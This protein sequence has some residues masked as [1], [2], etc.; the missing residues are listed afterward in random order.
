MLVMIAAQGNAALPGRVQIGPEMGEPIIE[1]RV[2][3]HFSMELQRQEVA[4]AAEGL[5]HISI[6]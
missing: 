4:A 2:L 3:T 6:G 5:M 1:A